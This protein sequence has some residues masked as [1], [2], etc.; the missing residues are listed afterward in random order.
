VW[1]DAWLRGI[2]DAIR[3]SVGPWEMMHRFLDAL[4]EAT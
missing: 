4:E 1:Y 3:V 2:G